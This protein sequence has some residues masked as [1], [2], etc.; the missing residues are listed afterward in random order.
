MV[1]TSF[2]TSFAPY[3]GYNEGV[4]VDDENK[5]D[6]KEYPDDYYLGPTESFVGSRV[7][8]KTKVTITG[9]SEAH[10]QLGRHPGRRLG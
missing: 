2:G 7:P 5:T 1:L 3:V 6:S 10:L 9:P 8:F 4:G